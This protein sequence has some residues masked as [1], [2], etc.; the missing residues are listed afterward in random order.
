MPI[1][2]RKLDTVQRRFRAWR[3]REGLSL[4][5]VQEAVNRVLPE[6]QQLSRGTVSNYERSEHGDGRRKRPPPVDF[7]KALSEAYP[8]LSFEWLVWG[9][10][11][12]SREEEDRRRGAEEFTAWVLE[13][14]GELPVVLWLRNTRGRLLLAEVVQRLLAAAS[15]VEEPT[16]HDVRQAGEI[17]QGLLLPPLALLRSGRGTLPGEVFDRWCIP[18][19]TAFLS[20]IPEA[21]EGRPLEEVL[22]RVG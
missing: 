4:R 7:L 11:Q 16:A 3:E 12:P 21:G 14:L 13:E 20:V 22:E 9:R 19:L 8:E 18:V 5:D 6:D 2:G 10:G 17:V 15:D 1:S